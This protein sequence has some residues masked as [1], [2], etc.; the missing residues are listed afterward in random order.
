MRRDGENEA[1]LQ[2]RDPWARGVTSLALD[3]L[4]KLPLEENPFA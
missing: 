1:F 2:P 4:V 3:S